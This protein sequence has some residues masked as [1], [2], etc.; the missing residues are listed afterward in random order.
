M[1]ETATTTPPLTSSG[2]VITVSEMRKLL[3][4]EAEEL[5]DSHIR[6]VIIALTDVANSQ[7]KSISSKNIQGCLEVQEVRK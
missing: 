4:V 2:L 3:G 5:S 1:E 7:L 6:D